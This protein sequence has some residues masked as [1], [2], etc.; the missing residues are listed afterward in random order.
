MPER[1]MEGGYTGG[2]KSRATR[3][4]RNLDFDWREVS[5]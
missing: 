4:T 5:S 3:H 1:L 2:L